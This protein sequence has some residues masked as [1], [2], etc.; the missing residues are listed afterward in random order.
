[1]PL[2]RNESDKAPASGPRQA[3]PSLASA[4]ADERWAAARA[5][6]DPA[7]IPSLGEALA[8][9]RDSRVREAIFTALARI[10]A[11][12]SAQVMLPYLRLDDANTRTGAMDALRAIPEACRPHLPE[13][14]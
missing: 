4:S 2:I 5:A 10:G 9:E 7:A 13:L 14:L 8:H 3:P 1:M 6:R 12:E 11:P